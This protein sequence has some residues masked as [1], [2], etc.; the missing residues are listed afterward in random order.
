MS[1]Q[2][3]TTIINI[4]KFY[5]IIFKGNVGVYPHP[6]D[7]LLSIREEEERKQRLGKRWFIRPKTTKFKETDTDIQDLKGPKWVLG[8]ELLWTSSCRIV[9]CIALVDTY[10]FKIAKD[11]YDHYIKVFH[12]LKIYDKVS[13]L[14]GKEFIEAEEQEGF[15][16]GRD[17]YDYR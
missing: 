17:R 9:S 16:C 4:D 5:V 3:C 2:Y 8:D 13:V 7:H 10:V 11:D 15:Y 14:K 1:K 12:R 6:Y